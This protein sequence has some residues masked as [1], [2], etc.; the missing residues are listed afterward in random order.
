MCQKWPNDNICADT[1]V[2]IYMHFKGCVESTHRYSQTEKFSLV[3]NI[4]D[5]N[6]VPN[7]GTYFHPLTK[8]FIN[9]DNGVVG[10]PGN[11]PPD[12]VNF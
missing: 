2:I 7:I 8:I 1:L 6:F 5:E 3:I 9:K 4:C 10:N 11:L 12:Q